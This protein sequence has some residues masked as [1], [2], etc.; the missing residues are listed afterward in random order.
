MGTREYPWQDT[1]AVLGRFAPNPGRAKERYVTFVAEGGKQ[2]KRPELQG[3]GLIRSVGGWA[4]VQEL[5]RGREG[6]ACG[7]LGDVAA[8]VAFRYF[9]VPCHADPA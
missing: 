1:R 3:G 2:G 4:A 5:R 6:Y 8:L 7:K 9:P